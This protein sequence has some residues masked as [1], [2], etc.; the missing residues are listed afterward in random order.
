MPLFQKTEKD[1]TNAY[2]AGAAALA[3]LPTVSSI[4]D[5]LAND[6]KAKA[7]R[8]ADTGYTGEITYKNL[9]GLKK[10][11]L[12]DTS[13]AKDLQ[14]LSV[15]GTGYSFSTDLPYHKS[16]YIP[17][18]TSSQLEDMIRNN[19]KF[20]SVDNSRIGVSDFIKGVRNAGGYI[21]IDKNLD[22]V[23]DLAHELGHARSL[24]A[25]SKR[26]GQGYKWLQSIGRTNPLALAGAASVASLLQEDADSPY[27][28][29]PAAIVAATQAPVLREEYLASRK[30]YDALSKLER[31]GLVEEGTSALAKSKYL[32][33][34]GTYLAGALGATAVPA[35]LA[36]A[37]Q[38]YGTEV[39]VISDAR[40]NL[41]N[42]SPLKT[43]LIAAGA[44]AGGAALSKYKPVSRAIDNL[45]GRRMSRGQDIDEAVKRIKEDISR[46]S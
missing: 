39:P 42:M 15:P 21:G 32:R 33:Y 30:G 29:A 14:V 24:S 34:G 7:R 38:R 44:L 4:S 41:S 20:L 43:G 2:L 18:L 19:K 23:T 31:S 1:K 9:E 17:G 35:L 16:R 10:E 11:I 28:Y 13:L 3:A 46:K 22:D 45:I 5:H 36:L 12:K 27:A 8:F 6:A 26:F 37:R 40:E 25:D